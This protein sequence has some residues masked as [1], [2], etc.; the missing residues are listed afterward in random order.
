MGNYYGT[1]QQIRLQKKSDAFLGWTQD[2]KGACNMARFLG[3]DDPEELGWDVILKHLRADGIF[4]FRM[5]PSDQTEGVTDRMQKAGYA[6]AY[7]DVFTGAASQ[8]LERADSLG[9]DFPDGIEPIPELQLADASTLTAVQDCMIRSGIAPFSGFMLSG[10]ACP[11]VLVALQTAQG[12][13]V[14]TAFGYFPHNRFS[15]HHKTAWG[16]LVAVDEEVRGRRLGV[17]V[18]SLMVR[19]CVEEIDAHTV[20]ELV[21]QDNLASRRMVERCGLEFNA[22]Y[23]SGTAS[24]SKERFTR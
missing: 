9:A 14:A 4:G 15:P 7:W 6:M 5:I 21:S 19:K 2:T 18:N 11:S 24:R 17:L 16:G 10:K 8:I 13:I 1:E 20:Y 12:R 3:T 22:F 23:K